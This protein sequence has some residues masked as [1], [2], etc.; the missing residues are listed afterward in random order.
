M[1]DLAHQTSA[2]THAQTSAT[3]HTSTVVTRSPDGSCQSTVTVTVQVTTTLGPPASPTF[4][5]MSPDE[6]D[7]NVGG[8]PKGG[9][10]GTESPDED[11]TNPGPGSKGS[12]LGGTESPDDDDTHPG[13]GS[14]G[15]SL[16][17]RE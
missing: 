13:P 14:K 6:D 10:G 12:S 8:G 17:G 4:T 15:S 11:D 5:K 16:G 2:P 7:T 3:P 9:L 1:T